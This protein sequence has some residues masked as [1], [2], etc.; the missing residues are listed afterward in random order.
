VRRPAAARLMSAR[1]RRSAVVFMP[2][3]RSGSGPERHHPCAALGALACDG[4]RPGLL[5][6]V[7]G[8]GAVAT[9][10][11]DSRLRGHGIS[12]SFRS[13]TVVTSWGLSPPCLHGVKVGFRSGSSLSPPASQQAG[14]NP[15]VQ[16]RTVSSGTRQSR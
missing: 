5:P 9:A 14:Q 1:V 2:A 7:F 6:V 16:S 13:L 4:C 15:R 3:L 10:F 11:E 8:A 12:G